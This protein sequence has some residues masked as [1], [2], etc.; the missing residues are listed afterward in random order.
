[1]IRHCSTA[2]AASRDPED[3]RAVAGPIVAHLVERGFLQPVPDGVG[4]LMQAVVQ[5]SAG[6]A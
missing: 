2:A 3:L 4:A 5:R 1:M 6:R